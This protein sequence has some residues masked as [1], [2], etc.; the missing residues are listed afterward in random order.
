MRNTKKPVIKGILCTQSNI[1]TFCEMHLFTFLPKGEW[2][3]TTLPSVQISIET[4]IKG[5]EH[6]ASSG[7]NKICQLAPLK[8]IN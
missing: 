3:D 7:G 6:L 8:R 4:E 1:W 2:F 5:K